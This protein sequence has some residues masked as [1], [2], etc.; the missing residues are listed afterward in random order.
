[1]KPA[2][3][4]RQQKQRRRCYVPLGS[5]LAGW[6]EQTITIE[7]GCRNALTLMPIEII[8]RPMPNATSYD[9]T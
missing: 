4:S 7:I 3:P 1:M 2:V 5:N 9:S 8:R 6:I